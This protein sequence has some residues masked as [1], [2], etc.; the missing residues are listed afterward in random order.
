MS[1]NPY[2]APQTES[3]VTGILSGKREDLRSVAMYQKGILICILVYFVAVFGQFAVPPAARIFMAI[4]VLVVGLIAAVFTFLLAMK[5][6]GTGPGILL[7][8]LCLVPCVG[9]IVLLI[10]NSKATNILKQNGIKVGLLGA[11]LNSI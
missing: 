1:S 11:D 6:H 9:L 2:E 4:G 3:R 5:T 7:G 8:I 10:I